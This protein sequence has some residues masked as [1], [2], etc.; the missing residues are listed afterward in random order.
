[1]AKSR[2]SPKKE[3]M[4]Q[5]SSKSIITAE[6]ASVSKDT[7]IIDV[8]VELS[9]VILQATDSEDVG[10]DCNLG[11]YLAGEHGHVLN[12]YRSLFPGAHIT[13]AI[14]RGGSITSRH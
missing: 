1:M 9:V 7:A 10:G 2:R 6:K 5:F 11:E 12:S 14:N 13:S 8:S 3:G 4:F